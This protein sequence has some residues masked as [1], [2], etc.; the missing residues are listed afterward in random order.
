MLFNLFLLLEDNQIQALVGDANEFLSKLYSSGN[1]QTI[2]KMLDLSHSSNAYKN[3]SL[4]QKNENQDET[5]QNDQI[6]IRK[7]QFKAN[8]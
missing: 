6:Q 3:K 8:R 7:Q 5:V 2:D 4:I 1:G